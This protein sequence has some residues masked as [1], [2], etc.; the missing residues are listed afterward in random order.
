MG[1]TRWLGGVMRVFGGSERSVELVDMMRA[2]G[3]KSAGLLFSKGMFVYRKKRGCRGDLAPNAWISRLKH[4][5][6]LSRPHN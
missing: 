4:C 3:M 2:L 1:W 5:S 6:R